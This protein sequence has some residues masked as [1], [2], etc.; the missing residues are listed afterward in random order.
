MD[1]RQ[2]LRLRPDHGARD[3][4]QGPRA[5]PLPAARALSGPADSGRGE[6][7]RTCVQWG[8]LAA[9]DVE[10]RRHI[11]RPAA[12]SARRQVD[13]RHQRRLDAGARRWGDPATAHG[14]ARKRSAR[15]PLRLCGK[16]A[17]ARRRAPRDPDPA[18][19]DRHRRPHVR[20]PRAYQTRQ[21]AAGDIRHPRTGAAHR[22]LYRGDSRPARAR[23][24]A[25]TRLRRT[26]SSSKARRASATGSARPFA[27]S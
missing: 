22:G 11:R 26:G 4:A 20:Q 9:D 8:Y 19:S 13:R 7:G 14:T 10:D 18:R 27:A 17:A 24:A 23:R 5:R 3:R 1:E 16:R 25:T 2:R 12:T 21:S 6:R 15:Q